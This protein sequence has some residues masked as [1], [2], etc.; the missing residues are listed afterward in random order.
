MWGF[1]KDHMEIV[2]GD[3][4]DNFSLGYDQSLQLLSKTE[5]DNK[6]DLSIGGKK[7]A[8]AYLNAKSLVVNKGM[9]QDTKTFLEVDEKLY[10]RFLKK[11]LLNEKG[12]EPLSN[13]ENI[14]LTLCAITAEP[15][16]Q[17]GEGFVIK[18]DFKCECKLESNVN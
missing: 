8:T 5:S 11:K 13:T 17:D 16:K 18:E 6:S 10:T 9:K 15:E 2:E 1:D 12:G 14:K 7:D 3:E 4:K